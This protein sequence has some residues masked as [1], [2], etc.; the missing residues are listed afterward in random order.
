MHTFNDRRILWSSP[1]AFI[2]AAAAAA[3]G[4][5]NIWRLPYLAGEYGGGAFLL[6][7]VLAL[8]VMGL[9]MLLAELLIGRRMRT[10]VVRMIRGWSEESALH[11][12]WRL[13]GYFAL[14]AA[15]MVLSYYSVIAGWGL[16]YM[17]RAAAGTLS[18]SESDLRQVFLALVRD[19]ER[20]LGW[21]TMFM[22]A[23]TIC[24]AH[25]VRRGLE[26]VT[27]WLLSA[28]FVCLAVLITIAGVNGQLGGAVSQLVAAD[29]GALGWRGVLEALH[30]AF[31]TLSLGVG[32]ML[33]LS[34]YLDDSTRLLPVASAV[35]GLDLA[36]A[37]GAGVAV[38][39]PLLA[40][41][42]TAAPGLALLFEVYPSAALGA[43]GEWAVML[44][45]VMLVLVALTSAVALMEPVIVWAMA[46]FGVSRVYA[47]TATGLTIWFLG[48]GTL[49]SF[50]L[51]ADVTVLGRTFFEWLS[52]LSARVLVPLVGLL[53]C[54]WIGRF[55]PPPAV[56]EA[57]GAHAPGAYELWRWCMRYP[58]RIG[59][60]LVGLYSIGAVGALDSIW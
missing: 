28:A 57:W 15:I 6:V 19:P 12:L 13:T 43:G 59:L 29:F 20:G 1:T 21:H 48:L 54:L 3:I 11:W 49:L 34:V 27:R 46:R 37:L 56:R 23:A 53:I 42:S 24:A 2:I 52:M 41:E 18:A 32:V 55:L 51:M 5:S 8:V 60:I 17:L 39:A 33:A 26:P 9:P 36:F 25:G 7:Y 31:F 16:A 10:D 45:F 22:V 30:Q 4:L 50:N 58:A 40:A 47:S 14:A 38:T 35:V 44:F